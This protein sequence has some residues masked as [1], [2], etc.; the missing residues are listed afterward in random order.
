MNIHSLMA[1]RPL[2]QDKRQAI[3]DAALELFERRGFHGTTVPD[4]A[5]AASVGA[6]TIYRY[7]AGKDELVNVLYRE[8]K[9][10]ITE[11]LIARIDLTAPARVIH[12]A[13]WNHYAEFARKYPRVQAFLELQHH[14]E[15][16][17]E[18]NRGIEE[19]MHLLARTIIERMKSERAVKDLPTELLLALV[20]GAL[21]GTMRSAWLGFMELSDETITAAE[22]CC[23]EAIRA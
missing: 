3:L 16:L 22:Q 20:F 5:R 6:G 1:A 10:K 9:M 8:W 12:Q 14:A 23:W 18:L 15:Y 21:M 19:R 11:E 17:D 4:I 13:L 2:S 7:F